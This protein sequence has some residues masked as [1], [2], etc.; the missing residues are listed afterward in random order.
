MDVP[1]SERAIE[2]LE[3]GPVAVQSFLP[4]SDLRLRLQNLGR[5]L[6]HPLLATFGFGV[7][8]VILR[9]LDQAGAVRLE[10]PP[11]FDRLDAKL[12]IDRERRCALIGLRD[13]L[14][15]GVGIRLKPGL[16]EFPKAS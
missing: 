15:L 1:L 13:P 4:P 11:R 14:L 8:D 2:P 6:E 7:L 16:E 3:E 9:R 5:Q 10:E 12:V